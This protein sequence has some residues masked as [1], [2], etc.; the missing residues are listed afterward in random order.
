MIRHVAAFALADSDPAVRTE[1]AAEAARRLEALVGVVPSLRSMSAGANALDL[2]G[3]WDLVLVADFDD[4]AGLDAY[5]VHP[6][7][8]EVA[9]FIG[10]IRSDRVAVDFEV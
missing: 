10:G 7:H 4:A 1:Q 3:N 9:A 8:E 6:A 2:P 5:Q